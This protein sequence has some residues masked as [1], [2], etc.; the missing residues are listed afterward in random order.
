[1]EF[2]VSIAGHMPALDALGAALRDADPAALVDEA[3]GQGGL[4][5]AASLS[6]PELER[7]LQAAGCSVRDIAPQPSVCCGGCSG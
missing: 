3:P 2:H 4:R 1:M 5:I 6:V 7:L